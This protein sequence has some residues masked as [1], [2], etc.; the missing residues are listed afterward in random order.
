MIV[1]DAL[2]R[3]LALAL[4]EAGPAK[5]VPAAEVKEEVHS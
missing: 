1:L 4:R 5:P 3:D 2:Q